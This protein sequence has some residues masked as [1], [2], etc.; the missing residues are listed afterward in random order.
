[1]LV[2]LAACTAILTWTRIA[3]DVL[4][5]AVVSCVAFVTSATAKKK[6][7]IVS[8]TTSGFVAQNYNTTLLRVRPAKCESEIDGG[9]VIDERYERTVRPLP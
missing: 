1:M 5:F 9:A 8:K 2:S 4:A 3:R 7:N 6:I